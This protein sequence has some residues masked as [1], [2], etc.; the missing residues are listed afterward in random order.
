MAYSYMELLG[1]LEGFLLQGPSMPMSFGLK[2]A[3]ICAGTNPAH[4]EFDRPGCL[5]PHVADVY[6]DLS[7]TSKEQ[8]MKTVIE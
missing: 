7:W 2:R 5:G 3:G 1:H 4:P 8:H 6:L